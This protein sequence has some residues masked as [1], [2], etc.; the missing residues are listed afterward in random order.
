MLMSAPEALVKYFIKVCAFIILEKKISLFMS[1]SFFFFLNPF[2]IEKKK[3]YRKQ[4]LTVEKKSY[5]NN[6]KKL[7]WKH[8]AHIINQISNFS[9][10][11]NYNIKFYNL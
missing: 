3:N 11:D 10:L 9:S 5:Y 8:I 2:T 4:L 1:N 7:D 6:N